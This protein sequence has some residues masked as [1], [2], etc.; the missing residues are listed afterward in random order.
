MPTCAWLRDAASHVK[1]VP[2]RDH[3]V[4]ASIVRRPEFR[5]HVGYTKAYEGFELE[6]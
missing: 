3:G 4:R 2:Y 6:S 1:N 5:Q